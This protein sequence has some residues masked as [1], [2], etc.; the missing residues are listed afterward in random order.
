MF[1][2]L[3][4]FADPCLLID[5]VVNDGGA[6]IALGWLK[7]FRSF[8]LAGACRIEG[9]D[10]QLSGKSGQQWHALPK[11][12]LSSFK[13]VVDDRKIAVSARE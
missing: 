5:E 9:L 12:L 10:Q 1:S 7:T 3:H 11:R 6:D 13:H 8:Y 2:C 4:L